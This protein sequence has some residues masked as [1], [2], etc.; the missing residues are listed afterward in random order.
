MEHLTVLVWVRAWGHL[1]VLLCA[2]DC[3]EYGYISQ[4]FCSS[5]FQ[6]RLGLVQC[7]HASLCFP[8]GTAAAGAL[9]P[10]HAVAVRM[11]A[12]L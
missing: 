1:Q 12:A 10:L 6:G 3:R 2:M 4:I 5:A 11:E 9:N 8:R 7:S